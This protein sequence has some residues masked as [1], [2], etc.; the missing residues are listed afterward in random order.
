MK[1]I[2]T[3]MVCTILAVGFT[4]VGC[5]K[6][7]YLSRDTSML[8]PPPIDTVK[9]PPVDPT[10][11]VFD[12]AD[13]KDGWETVGS[14]NITT[15]GQKEGAGYI[16]N[17]IPNGSDFMQFIKHLATPLDSKLNTSNGQFSFWWF[18][19]DVSLLKNDGQ[20]EIT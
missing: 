15:P 2:K 18:V 19:S 12:N 17:T 10:L 20:I 6:E 7:K 9:P 13:V 14:V 16:T 3:M 1:F 4:I 11:V 8:K 5:K